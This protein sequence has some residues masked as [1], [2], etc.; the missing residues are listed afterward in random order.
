[1][2]AIIVVL[3]ILLIGAVVLLV[4]QRRYRMR[5]IAKSSELL[6]VQVVENASLRNR[7]SDE[8]NENGRLRRSRSAID[9][10]YKVMKARNEAAYN[11]AAYDREKR[12]QVERML[13]Q[14][15]AVIEKHAEKCETIL[16]DVVDSMV[17][18][19]RPSKEDAE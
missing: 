1:M 9:E 7:L 16:T 17:S 18:E 19:L 10:E 6:R 4:Q 8:V 11:A 3:V 13:A 12:E 14:K 2:I 15:D 5:L